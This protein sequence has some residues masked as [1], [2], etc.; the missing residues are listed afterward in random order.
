MFLWQRREYLKA[1]STAWHDMKVSI[2][3]VQQTTFIH[4]QVS[5]ALQRPIAVKGRE[6]LAPRGEDRYAGVVI[7]TD[8][9]SLAGVYGYAH[10]SVNL[11]PKPT[12]PPE[13]PQELP[14]CR[15]DVHAMI[16]IVC[17]E[18]VSRP[19]ACHVQYPAKMAVFRSV[20]PEGAIIAEVRVQD[21]DG[22]PA[23]VHVDPS[24][25]RVE[26]DIARVDKVAVL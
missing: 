26:G 5:R 11:P 23:T 9:H 18:D 20:F 7:L 25:G 2:A 10:R 13:C 19:V 1:A 3:N 16:I 8:I 17:Y 4:E 12:T 22:I 24:I 14:L 15:E 6:K 21:A